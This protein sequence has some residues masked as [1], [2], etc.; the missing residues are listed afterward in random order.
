MLFVLGC[1]SANA[2]VPTVSTPT[3]VPTSTL[4][5][6]TIIPSLTQ[7]TLPIPSPTFA[8][9]SVL[10]KPNSPKS[11][12]DQIAEKLPEGAIC[13]I[14]STWSFE[15]SGPIETN[16]ELLRTEPLLR[17]KSYI[18]ITLDLHGY[19]ILPNDASALAFVQGPW[20]YVSLADYVTNGK[21]GAQVVT[22]PLAD[23]KDPFTGA[24]LDT[25]K[26]V[27]DIHARFWSAEGI[28]F[29]KVTIYYIVAYT[30]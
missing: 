5:T 18:Q 9:F 17:G 4:D 8:F 6:I 11:T 30:R 7:E 3:L 2:V 10:P 16:Q 23:F 22:I 19:K 14:D 24:F 25:N 26:V 15:G 27:T 13:L 28:D 21:D 20:K 1:S 29:Y 12:C